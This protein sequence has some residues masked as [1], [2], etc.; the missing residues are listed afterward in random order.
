M[1]RR[2][3]P[4]P[5]WCCEQKGSTESSNYGAL[6]DEAAGSQNGAEA[7]EAEAKAGQNQMPTGCLQEEATAA[8]PSD[9]LVQR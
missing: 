7:I 5:S 9:A 3:D 4:E 6:G 8:P 2:G 1:N